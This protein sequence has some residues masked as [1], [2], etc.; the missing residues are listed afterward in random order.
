LLCALEGVSPPSSKADTPQRTGREGPQPARGG[1]T[2]RRAAQANAIV[3][4]T[5]LMPSCTLWVTLWLL[6]SITEIVL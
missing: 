1:R 3:V 6:V 5:A 2:G 4:G